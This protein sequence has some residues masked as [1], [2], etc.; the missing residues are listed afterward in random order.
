MPA[1]SVSKAELLELTLTAFGRQDVTVVREPGREP[2]DRTLNTRD[3]QANER[4][5]RGAGYERPP[6]IAEMLGELAG[7]ALPQVDSSR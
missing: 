7:V 2:I 1:D 6:T 3:Q 4:L 5:W